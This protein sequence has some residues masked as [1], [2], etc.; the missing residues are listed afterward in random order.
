MP[1]SLFPQIHIK[2]SLVYLLAWHP[3]LHTP[4]IS[5]SNHC[6]LFATYAH[7]IATCFAVVPTTEIISSNPTLSLN[8]LLGILSCRFMPHI[9]SVCKKLRKRC[10][11]SYLN[12][13]HLCLLKCHLIFLSYWPGVTSMQ[14]TN[15]YTTAVQ[16]PSHCQ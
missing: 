2:F 11:H 4:Y 15:L 1:D 14:H 6:L 8:P 7:T 10:W 16:S 12:H 9:H 5:S 3:P 13:S